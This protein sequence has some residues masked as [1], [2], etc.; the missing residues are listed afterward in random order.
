MEHGIPP[1]ARN[2]KGDTAARNAM[3]L[4]DPIKAVED[5]IIPIEKF[6]QVIQSVQLFTV[7]KK[8]QS[9]NDELLNEW[10]VGP[11]GTGKSRHVRT[12]WPDAFIKSNDVWWDG[13]NGEETVIIEE[14]GPRQIGGHHLKIWSDHYHFKAAVK[15]SQISIRPKRVI[16]TSNYDIQECFTE[17]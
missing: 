2:V 10:H 5:G 17:Q 8:D 6:K 14:M 9:H 16:I 1:A 4:K 12:T 7:M 13:Y 15:G 11:T 3:I